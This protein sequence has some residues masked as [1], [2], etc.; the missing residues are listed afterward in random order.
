MDLVNNRTNFLVQGYPV[1]T[2]ESGVVARF[3]Q[4]VLL[5]PNGP[6]VVSSFPYDEALVSSEFK[7]T[8]DEINSLI[9]APL[10]AKKN[11]KKENK[12]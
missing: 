10:R 2:E 9:L 7:V 12:E 5:M 6:L 8:D 3:M 11:K 4:T 1:L